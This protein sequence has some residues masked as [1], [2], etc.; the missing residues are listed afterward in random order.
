[1]AQVI[2]WFRAS[3]SYYPTYSMMLICSFLR[4][5]VFKYHTQYA[6]T[7]MLAPNWIPT[8]EYLLHLDYLMLKTSIILPKSHFNKYL[9]VIKADFC[10]LFTGDRWY[11]FCVNN[12]LRTKD[13][14]ASVYLHLKAL[15]HHQFQQSAF[16]YYCHIHW[17][18]IQPNIMRWK[19]SVL[20][21]KTI[22]V[23]CLRES[24]A[25]SG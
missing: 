24:G 10:D 23:G 8:I 7:H 4:S 12:W 6:Q 15:P 16:L 11:T 9:W 3:S 17:Y 25:K 20:F 18:V 21:T 13:G 19:E 14:Q 1:M 5:I 2:E 22:L